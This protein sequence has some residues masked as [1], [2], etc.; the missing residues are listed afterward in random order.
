MKTI[1]VP[2]DFSPASI[3]AMN[4]AANLASSIGASVILFHAYQVPVAF[5]E[6]PVVTISMEEMKKISDEKIQE[7]KHNLEH[8]SSGKLKIY[9]ESRLGDTIDEL[10]N[11]C[12]AIN[13]FAVVMGTRGAGAIER[14]FLGSNTLSAVKHLN[15]PVIII[16]PGATFRP[17]HKIGFT[18]D[19]QHVVETTP[20][21]IIKDLC[22]IFNAELLVLNVDYNNKHFKPDVPEQSL[23]L[24]NMLEKLNPSYHFIDNPNVEEG[25]HSF[26]ETHGIDL[27][28]TIPKKHK[29]LE[30]LFQK[31]HTRELAFHSHIPILAIHEG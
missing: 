31:S 7:L 30:G 24:H 18:C 1:I 23:L 22:E 9:A 11:Y 17:I 15:W 25:I 27:I 8:I 4:Y 13:P 12:K 14:I 28:I 16:P 3:N 19:F 2:T 20:V 21:Q 26:A 29:L 5:S 10:E 6:V